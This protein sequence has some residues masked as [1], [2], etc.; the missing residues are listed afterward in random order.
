MPHTCAAPT[1]FCRPIPQQSTRDLQSCTA[2]PSNG[3][4]SQ[5]VSALLTATAEGHRST[6]TI[7][8]LPLGHTSLLYQPSS[9]LPASVPFPAERL[10]HKGKEKDTE[11][12]SCSRLH[13][14]STPPGNPQFTKT[15]RSCNVALRVAGPSAF[16]HAYGRCWVLG[17][18]QLS[19]LSNCSR[20][21]T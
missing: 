11:Y 5:G 18:M 20:P 13:N 7:P 12:R 6:N 19:G 2:T 17:N 3:C 8:W 21:L 4:Q 10:H 9:P 16:Q 15:A 1:M 14:G